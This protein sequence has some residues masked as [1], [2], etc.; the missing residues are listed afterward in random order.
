MKFLKDLKRTHY[1]GQLQK[2]N[3]GQDVVLMGW[4]HN[5]RDHGGLVF[6]DLRDREGL[7]QI[8]FAPEL[9]D[10]FKLAES[11]RSEFVLAVRG[12][13]QILVLDA[14][15]V[16]EISRRLYGLEAEI[17]VVT[18]DRSQRRAAR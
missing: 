17:K 7:V 13:V 16:C 1:C 15:V 8:V 10:I 4:V 2:A 11:V 6:L 18:G 14:F 3:V 9:A 5:R 12:H